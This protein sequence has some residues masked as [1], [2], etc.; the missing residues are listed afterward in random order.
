MQ[1]TNEAGALK[2]DLNSLPFN[3]LIDLTMPHEIYRLLGNAEP[4]VFRDPAELSDGYRTPERPTM[5]HTAINS[6]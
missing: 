5:N 1:C 4:A 6:E 2:V 3:H